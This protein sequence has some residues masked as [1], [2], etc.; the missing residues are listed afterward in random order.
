MQLPGP[1]LGR[2]A[3]V[4]FCYVADM[5][6]QIHTACVAADGR[7][8]Q[9]MRTVEQENR[10]SQ[11]CVP[12]DL[13]RCNRSCSRSR[14]RSGRRRLRRP[15][16]LHCE[17]SSDKPGDADHA[18]G[19]V[20]DSRSQTRLRIVRR[21]AHDSIL[22]GIIPLGLEAVIGQP[23]DTTTGPGRGLHY[24]E[25]YARARHA[26]HSAGPI[27]VEARPLGPSPWPIAET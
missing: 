6:H 27:P 21:G 17:S 15:E 11:S 4:T 26:C 12:T 9:R 20:Q 22:R 5:T 2:R 16:L 18:S 24:F 7:Y 10:A 1:H 3:K 23:G 25:A 14:D 8:S 19:H 13:G